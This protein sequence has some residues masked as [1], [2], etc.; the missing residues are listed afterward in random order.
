MP[1]EIKHIGRNIILYSRTP[2]VLLYIRA[3]RLFCSVCTRSLFFF[4][5]YPICLHL[6]VPRMR[7]HVLMHCVS[8]G[9]R[10]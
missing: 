1:G 6:L 5:F 4:F 2:T 8:R 3:S 10:I 7:Q 9:V